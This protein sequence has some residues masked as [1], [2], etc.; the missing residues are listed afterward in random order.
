MRN[1]KTINMWLRHASGNETE[2]ERDALRQK[3]TEHELEKRTL[4]S[5]YM[6]L[7]AISSFTRR[8]IRHRTEANIP[9]MLYLCQS[10]P[11]LQFAPCLFP[12]VKTNTSQECSF[13]NLSINVTLTRRERSLSVNRGH[14]SREKGLLTLFE[15]WGCQRGPECLYVSQYVQ[16]FEAQNW[17]WSE[18][19][20]NDLQINEM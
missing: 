2:R 18:R 14:M 17:T 20:E 7:F 5:G 1:S 12:N 4:Q 19:K 6:R 10:L 3:Q 8:M 13:S 16:G 9:S 11:K 15:F